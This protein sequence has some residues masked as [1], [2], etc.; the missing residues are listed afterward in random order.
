MRD[1]LALVALTVGV[2]GCGTIQSADRPTPAGAELNFGG[3]VAA[4]YYLGRIAQIDDEGPTLKRWMP[5][6]QGRATTIRKRTS[7]L[8]VELEER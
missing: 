1:I 3:E 4:R 5:R 2:A 7:H 8:T 6:A